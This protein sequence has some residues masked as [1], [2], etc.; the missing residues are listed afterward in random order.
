[1]VKTVTLCKKLFFSLKVLKAKKKLAITSFYYANKDI[2]LGNSKK[3]VCIDQSK[4]YVFSPL[5]EF[6][7][8]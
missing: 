8:V 6:K 5:Q 2:W 3:L 1:M 7:H 4:L